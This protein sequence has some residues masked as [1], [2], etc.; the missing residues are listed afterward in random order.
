[1]AIVVTSPA[2]IFDL[3]ELGGARSPLGW[4]VLR[5]MAAQGSTWAAHDGEKLLCLAGLYPLGN[6]AAEA[7][8]NIDPGAGRQALALLR[9]VKLTIAAS[10]YREIVAVCGT[11]AGKRLARAVGMHFCEATHFGEVWSWK[12][13]SA[14][15]DPPSSSSKPSSARAS[16]ISPA[17]RAR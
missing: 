17:S 14:A 1:M 10:G 9:L 8:F 3:A 15:I 12:D 2:T 11:E 4:R 16:P 6:G 13:Y 5:L 7:W